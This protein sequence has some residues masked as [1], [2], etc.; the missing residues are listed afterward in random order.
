MHR[1]VF[2]L[3]FWVSAFPDGLRAADT[4]QDLSP[5]CQDIVNLELSRSGQW[6][7]RSLAV[8]RLNSLHVLALL[9]LA[10][11]PE[12]LFNILGSRRPKATESSTLR[13]CSSRALGPSMSQESG[14]ALGIVNSVPTRV[15]MHK[16]DWICTKCGQLSDKKKRFCHRCGEPRTV[17]TPTCSHTGEFR[18]G[19]WLC[20][21]CGSINKAK[22]ENC[23][24]CNA[25]RKVPVQGKRTTQYAG[26]T[27][28]RQCGHMVQG[29]LFF[30][31]NCLAPLPPRDKGDL[32]WRCQNCKRLNA[33]SN[34]KCHACGTDKPADEEVREWREKEEEDSKILE[35][36][37]NVARHPPAAEYRVGTEYWQR[38]WKCPVCL[39]ASNWRAS[40]WCF[41]CRSPN[42]RKEILKKYWPKLITRTEKV[43]DIEHNLDRY[44][45]YGDLAEK[46]EGKDKR[47]KRQLDAFRKG[48]KGRGDKS[49][50]PFTGKS[51]QGSEGGGRKNW[52]RPRND[53][54][55]V[56]VGNL[57]LG[58]SWQ[59]LKELMTQAGTVQFASVLMPSGTDL[60]DS[61]A[62]GFVRYA[63]EAEAKYAIFYMNG[64][65]IGNRAITVDAWTDRKDA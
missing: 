58:T 30:C 42:P 20:S 47:S 2:A 21:V 4:K 18:K 45:W 31:E 25:V 9:F 7:G 14:I 24:V 22:N 8:S 57:P 52:Q 1:A 43:V 13:C 60:S 64:M 56:Y 28:C 41:K 61:T 10:G 29:S 6:D 12:A 15:M 33:Y 51:Q 19:T 35:A 38:H 17:D 44:V 53:G 11:T 55:E 16:G 5:P 48:K 50:R 32:R 46:A 36:T 23:A 3:A 34:T 62:P 37:I 39:Y 26:D 65:Q 59:E 27:H 54:T 49:R 63:T 40:P